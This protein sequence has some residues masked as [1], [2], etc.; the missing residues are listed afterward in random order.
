M[1]SCRFH[2]MIDVQ[3]N[4]F[5][6]AYGVY[7]SHCVYFM[8]SFTKVSCQIQCVMLDDTFFGA[9]TQRVLCSAGSGQGLCTKNTKYM[10]KS[11][12]CAQ[13]RW[14]IGT[15]GTGGIWKDSI[16]DG[17]RSL[18]KVYV[19]ISPWYRRKRLCSSGLGQAVSVN[20]KISMIDSPWKWI[21]DPYPI[22][23]LTCVTES[24][25]AWYLYK[26]QRT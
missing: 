25:Q 24:E 16:N 8:L 3:Q 21:I 17:D 11:Y 1:K 12:L 10:D 26:D 22:N 18:N 19:F 5:L 20:F 9:Y 4:L 6:T 23:Q 14:H 7:Y 15:G 13:G 2:S